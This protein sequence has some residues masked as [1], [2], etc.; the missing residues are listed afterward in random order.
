VLVGN[1]AVNTLAGGAGND[2]YQ[3]R[4]GADVLND[5]STTSN[6]VYQWGVG[7]GNDS[8]T[9]AGGSDRIEIGIGVSATQITFTRATADLKIALAGATDVLTVKGWYTSTANRIEEIRLADG[10]VVN[11]GTVAPASAPAEPA[12]QSASTTDRDAQIMVQAMAQFTG[13]DALAESWWRETPR[14]VLRPDLLTPM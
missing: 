10:T 1:T 4:G 9:A 6:D 2:T 7:Q 8:I 13:R 5:A 3:G 11:L 14:S 12:A